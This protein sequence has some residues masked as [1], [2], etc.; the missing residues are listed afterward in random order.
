MDQVNVQ[1]V[2]AAGSRLSNVRWVWS[3]MLAARYRLVDDGRVE[4]T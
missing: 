4:H 2:L 1:T 3:Q